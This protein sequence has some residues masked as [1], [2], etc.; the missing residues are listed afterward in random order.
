MHFYYISLL[1]DLLDEYGVTQA[2]LIKHAKVGK[3]VVKEP[4]NLG[5]EHR[6][7]AQAIGSISSRI[8]TER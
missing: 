5:A 8:T 4:L 7:R 2:A 1:L 6:R 3:M